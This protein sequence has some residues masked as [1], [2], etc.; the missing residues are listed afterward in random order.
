MTNRPKSASKELPLTCPVGVTDCPALAEAGELRLQVADLAAQSR[1]D[2]LTGLAN[3]RSFREAL[4]QEMERTQRSDQ[5]T[6]LIMLDIDFF[7][8][9]NDTWG[10]EVG[11]RALVHLASLMVQTLRKLDIPCRYG[12]EEFA[13]ILPDTDLA[14]SLPVAER[15]REAIAA[16]PVPVAGQE[17]ALTVSLGLSCYTSKEKQSAEELIQEADNYL[18]RAKESGRN[19]TCHAEIKAVAAVSPDERQALADLFGAP[20]TDNS[21]NKP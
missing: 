8:Q 5:P 21:E 12:G 4:D 18:Y 13:V 6:S 19:R 11:N 14:A 9:V 17:L 20:A 1:T 2:T 10:H 16:T 3:Y 15:L 7:K